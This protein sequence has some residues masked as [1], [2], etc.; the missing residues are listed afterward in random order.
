[1]YMIKGKS[2]VFRVFSDWKAEVEK[3]LGQNLTIITDGSL[4]LPSL[5]NTSEGRINQK[6]IILTCPESHQVVYIHIFHAP[7]HSF[8]YTLK[9]THY[10]TTQ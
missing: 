4:P 1:M 8:L 7:H 3:S 2:D 9:Y 6:L 10:M 5:V